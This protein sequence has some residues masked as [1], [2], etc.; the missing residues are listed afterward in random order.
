MKAATVPLFWHS[1]VLL[2][3]RGLLSIALTVAE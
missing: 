1:H 3:A 2:R